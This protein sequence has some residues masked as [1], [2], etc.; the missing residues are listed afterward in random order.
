MKKRVIIVGAGPG[1]LSAAM[2]LAKRGFDVVVYEKDDRPGG[3]NQRID[4]D[5]YS[6]DT[7]P[8]FLMLKSVLDEVFRQAG[9]DS[10]KLLNFKKIDPMYKLVYDKNKGINPSSDHELMKKEIKELFPGKEEALDKYLEV[11]KK[12]FEK[13]FACLQ[14]PY[15]KILDFFS[16]Q[17]INAIPHFSLGKSL[18]DVLMKYFDDEK[19]ALAFTF[20]AK[21]LGM[22]PWECPGAYALI[23]YI[24]HAFG[25]YHVEG[26]LCCISEAMAELAV[27]NGA[28]I[29]FSTPVKKIITEKAA[30]VGVQL[31]NGEEVKGDEVVINAD[32]GYAATNLFDKGVLKKY[33]PEKVDSMKYSCSI[34][35]LYL[36]VDKKYDLP[37]H[38]IYFADDYK[39]NVTDIFESK[40][41]SEDI[42]FYVRNTA[43]VDNTDS[44]EGHSSL[45]ILVPVANLDAETDW[46]KEKDRYRKIVLDAV[47][48]KTE[49]KDLREHIKAEKIITPLDWEKEYNVYKGATFNLAHNYSQMLYFRPHNQFEDV[50]N[51]YLCGGGTHPGSGLP[52]IYE[53]GRISA[54][55]ISR[56]YNMK[57]D[58]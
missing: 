19:L 45:Y 12:R 29:N 1:G 54:D 48:K 49:M 13:M 6:F 39:T 7:G 35:M 24:E 40:K 20:Q 26:G 53:S 56:K 55:L 51:V 52:T 10:E 2:I 8:T 4:L 36:G 16:S 15:G 31:E 22:S 37:F 21:Y 50:K 18:M 38:S 42:S 32:F 30:A 14:K 11:E 33:T 9:G 44:P 25:I 43:G 57:Y 46:E 5:G 47:E 41:L 3:R 28:E 17:F 27:K 58:K 23:S 34:F